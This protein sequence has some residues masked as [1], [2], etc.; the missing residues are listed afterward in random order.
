MKKIP[1]SVII[2]LIRKYNVQRAYY[3]NYPTGKVWSNDFNGA[4]YKEALGDMI[5]EQEKSPL[6]L[7]IH[8]PIA[9]DFATF[10]FVI[11][12][13]RKIA[14]K[15]INF[16]MIWTKRF[17]FLKNYLMTMIACLILKKYISA[18][19]LYLT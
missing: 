10:A 11:Q 5:R 2:N 18:A 1:D 13:L 6:T 14:P 4:D 12:R 17:M 8:F 9:S 15:S 16:C 19:A 7:Y 3:T